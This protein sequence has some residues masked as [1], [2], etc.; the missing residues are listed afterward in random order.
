MAE[1]TVEPLWHIFSIP[2]CEYCQQAKALFRENKIIYTESDATEENN[3]GACVGMMG[4][5]NPTTFPQIFHNKVHIGGYTELRA[6]FENGEIDNYEQS[7][8]FE[9][10][11]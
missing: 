10:V 7:I 4:Y 11:E 5:I 1:V 6:I 8:P 9:R 3:L 2:D